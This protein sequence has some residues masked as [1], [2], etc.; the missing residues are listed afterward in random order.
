MAL[1]PAHDVRGKGIYHH[2]SES[3]RLWRD[4][5]NGG[6]VKGWQMG[7]LQALGN[8][9]LMGASPLTPAKTLLVLPSTLGV[10]G[11]GCSGSPPWP[12]RW[13]KTERI[14]VY[15]QQTVALGPFWLAK[16]RARKIKSN[17][18]QVYQFSSQEIPFWLVKRLTRKIK[19]STI[20][21]YQF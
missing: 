10:K 9:C 19:F 17:P 16:T 8:G 2:A 21:V 13:A 7:V 11:R 6:I 12:Y 20:Q 1:R 4:R 14:S 15:A 5:S 18:L 3:Q